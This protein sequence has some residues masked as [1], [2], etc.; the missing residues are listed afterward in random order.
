MKKQ[1]TTGTVLRAALLTL[2]LGTAAPAVLAHTGQRMTSPKR[3]RLS[4]PRKK[5]SA[6]RKTLKR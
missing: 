6:S 4:P 2:A 1:S 3:L 5:R